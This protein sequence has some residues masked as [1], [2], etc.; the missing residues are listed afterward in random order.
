M[1][2]TSS[3]NCNL[4]IY[5]RS[6]YLHESVVPPNERSRDFYVDC[7]VTHKLKMERLR[8][9]WWLGKTDLLRFVLVEVNLKTF[10]A[11][12]EKD[13]RNCYWFFFEL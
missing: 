5:T 3:K 12:S 4:E 9:V 6:T 1:H 2:M 8:T 13:L 10:L 7:D 11:H